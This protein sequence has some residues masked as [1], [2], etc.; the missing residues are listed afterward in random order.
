MMMNMFSH[1]ESVLSDSS[2]ICIDENFVFDREVSNTT[3]LGFV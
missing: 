3:T 2:V 1:Q